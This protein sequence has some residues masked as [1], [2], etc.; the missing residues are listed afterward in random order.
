MEQFEK[1]PVSLLVSLTEAGA[2]HDHKKCEPLR[3]QAGQHE[4]TPINPLRFGRMVNIFGDHET[5]YLGFEDFST[6]E[7][8]IVSESG[9]VRPLTF[10]PL[11]KGGTRQGK[12]QRRLHALVARDAG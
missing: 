4:R 5:D 6:R 12:R 10:A 2:P 8:F 7:D 11:E 3:L 1:V 9:E